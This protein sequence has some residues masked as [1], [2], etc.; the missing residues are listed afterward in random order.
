MAMSEGL[1]RRL[2]TV[3]VLA[4][5]ALTAGCSS[6]EVD[7]RHEVT[8]RTT[9]D[10]STRD[11]TVWRPADDGPWPVVVAL[12]GLGGVRGDLDALAQA[13]AARGMVVFVPDFEQSTIEADIVCAIGHARSHAVEEG[14][15][16]GSPFVV[17]GH[18]MGASIALLTLNAPPEVTCETPVTGNPDLVVAVSGCHDGVE[19]GEQPFDA[20]SF[21]SPGVPVLLI[22]GEA[23]ETCP[24][25]QSERAAE[26]LE[27]AGREVT[28][29]SLPGAG[30]FD[31]I[32]HDIVDGQYVLVEDDPAGLAT[33]HA[34]VDAL[35]RLTDAER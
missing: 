23:D 1:A 24:A 21:G 27:D 5:A 25:A 19:A 33:V 11:I 34:V 26:A 13:L 18:S 16:V 4:L 35:A 17:L 6:S 32:F 22:G 7:Q 31:P 29:V 8:S 9:S 3:T 10:A 30:H 28:F 20:A 14:G 15:G 2:L 12:H